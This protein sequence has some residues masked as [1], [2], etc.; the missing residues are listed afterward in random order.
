MGAI[1]LQPPRAAAWTARTATAV[2]NVFD[3][4]LVIYALALATFGLL[5]AYSNSPDGARLAAGGTFSRALMWLAL[6]VVAFTLAT[7]FDYRWLRTFSWPVYLLN[8]ALLVV[9]L[10]LGSGVGGT[11]R[12]VTIFGVQFQFSEIAKIL[13]IIVLANFIASRGQRVGHLSTILGAGFVALPPLALVLSQP[14]LGTSLVFGAV[15][16]G[17]LFMSGASLKW[18]AIFAAAAVAAVPV[19]W[20]ELLHNYQRQRILA[21]LDPTNDPTNSGFQVIQSQ[22][23]VGSGGVFGLGLT[24]GTTGT[25]DYLPV[26][27]TDFAG[28]VLLQELGFV[29]GLVV[30]LLFTALLWRVMLVGW[31]SADPFGLAFA[32]GIASLL[33]FQLLVNLGMILG[34]MPVTG[35]PLPFI[36]HGGAS[37]ISVAIGLGILQSINL[38]QARPKW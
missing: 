23:A 4:Q 13:T 35:I 31:R 27:T 33:L 18:M 29:G 8:L 6:A 24:H 32:A 38:R 7:A 19:I 3:I 20:T 12:W 28:A 17:V 37:I 16:A 22:I 11:S 5:I 9:T 1:R 36:T 2:W 14:D 15:L 30:L 10:A 21:F 26:S 25:S 34:L